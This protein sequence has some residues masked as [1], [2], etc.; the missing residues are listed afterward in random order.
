MWVVMV[1]ILF[2][3]INGNWVSVFCTLCIPAI[4]L[5]LPWI[6]LIEFL[7][8]FVF[9]LCSPKWWPSPVMLTVRSSQQCVAVFLLVRIDLGGPPVKIWFTS[10][11]KKNT[12]WLQWNFVPVFCICGKLS[13]PSA[14]SLSEFIDLYIFTQRETTSLLNL[15]VSH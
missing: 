14:P 7:S 3:N 11:F 10:P 8:V 15:V 4:N 12:S 9:M 13:F 1:K 6:L 2:V 5:H